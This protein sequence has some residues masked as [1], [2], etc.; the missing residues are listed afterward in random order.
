MSTSPLSEVRVPVA[1]RHAWIA[2]AAY[3][4]AKRRGFQGGCSLEDW[5]EAEREI[6]HPSA[7]TTSSPRVALVFLDRS[8][9]SEA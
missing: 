9:A 2:E 6:G 5:L 7:Q 3:Y 1:E 4:R 8:P